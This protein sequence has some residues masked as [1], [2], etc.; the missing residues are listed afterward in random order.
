MTV[1]NPCLTFILLANISM[2]CSQNQLP[3]DTLHLLDEAFE[4]F[5]IPKDTITLIPAEICAA[6]PFEKTLYFQPNLNK[7]L[8]CY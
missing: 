7:N 2:G 6:D 8:D 3:P 4:A 1:K 5:N